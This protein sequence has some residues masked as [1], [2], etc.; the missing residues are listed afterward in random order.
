MSNNLVLV[1][2]TETTGLFPKNNDSQKKEYPYITQLSFVVYDVKEKKIVHSYNQYIKQPEDTDYS[3]QAF[4]ITK[5]TKEMCDN[6]VLITDALNEFYKYYMNVKHIVAHNLDF[7][8]QMIELEILRHFED[9]KINSAAD[10]WVLF[11]STFNKL[12]NIETHCSMYMGKYV[13]KLPNVNSTHKNNNYKLPKLV[14][15]HQYLFKKTPIDL[16]DAYKDCLVCL[17]CFV[18]MKFNYE[19]N[20]KDLNLQYVV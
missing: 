17:K 1:F 7:D 11:N 16:H 15:L 13:C 14:E 9:L 5:I 12:W 8:K 2:D 19:V 4:K 10:I 18:K 3:S 6:G 20:D